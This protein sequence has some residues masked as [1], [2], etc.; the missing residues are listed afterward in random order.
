METRMELT[1]KKFVPVDYD[2]EATLYA[3]LRA[4]PSTGGFSA[5]A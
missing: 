3:K 4:N 1:E 5:N 2:W